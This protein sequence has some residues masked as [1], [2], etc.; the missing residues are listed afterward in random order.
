MF[1]YLLID[2]SII[3]FP[4][5]FSFE[6]KLKFYKNLKQV[7]VSIIVVGIPLLIWDYFANLNRVW[8]FSN[9]YTIGF[10]ILG[11]PIEEILF[12]VV[13]PYSMIFL[14]ET[15]NYY[16]KYKP[17]NIPKSVFAVLA[18]LSIINALINFNLNYTFTIFFY[19]SIIFFISYIIKF[20]LFNSV[21]TI[22]FFLFSFIPF[23]AANYI[24]TS[25]PIVS[26][27]PNEFS[28]LRI[29]TIPL[30]DF[31]Y[32]FLLVYSYILIYELA[33]RDTIK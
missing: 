3:L 14:W 1:T 21:T 22:I 18:L 17:N 23:F 28:N 12:F 25:L 26:Y 29:T 30:E 32:S 10:R 20:K 19:L 16:I 6:Q 7:F 13:V 33:K 15:F 8:S 4:L 5:I 11:L 31:F 9:S 27:N 24:L 2:I